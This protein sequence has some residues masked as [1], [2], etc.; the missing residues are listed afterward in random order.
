MVTL[1]VDRIR[2]FDRLFRGARIGLIT[3]SSGVSPTSHSL[4]SPTNAPSASAQ[5][6]QSVFTSSHPISIGF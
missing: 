5:Q 1:G 6:T 4:Q 3:N 2:A